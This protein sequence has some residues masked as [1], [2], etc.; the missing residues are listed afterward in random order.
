MTIY[1]QFCMNLQCGS[2]NVI[3]VEKRQTQIFYVQYAFCTSIL[4]SKIIQK[5]KFCYILV[6]RA[7]GLIVIRF[8]I[9]SSCT[10]ILFLLCYL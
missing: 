3:G 10:F 1:V 8:Y 9:V 5:W 6:P 2:L 4:I 7:F